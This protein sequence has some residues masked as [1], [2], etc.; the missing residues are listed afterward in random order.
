M[1][2]TKKNAALKKAAKKNITIKRNNQVIKEG[3]PL[4]HD[5]KHDIPRNRRTVG[6]NKGITRN[7]GDFESLRVDVWLTDEV[8]EC[9]SLQDAL[10]RIETVLDEVLESA[11]M[12]MI[13]EK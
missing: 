2:H 9:E 3:I 7:M 5:V 1:L 8:G 10:Y 6:M 12:S 13:D 4:D 11:V